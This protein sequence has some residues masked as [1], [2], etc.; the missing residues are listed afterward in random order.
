M[1]SQIASVKFTI[2]DK[3][4]DSDDDNTCTKKR[5]VGEDQD[6]TVF[7]TE[8]SRGYVQSAFRHLHGAHAELL[9]KKTPFYGNDII[10]KFLLK[11]VEFSLH[12]QTSNYKIQLNTCNND[13]Q[14]IHIS[15]TGFHENTHEELI[16]K[17]LPDLAVKRVIEDCFLRGKVNEM[18]QGS[19]R[20]RAVNVGHVYR[21]HPKHEAS[22]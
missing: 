9:A 7:N 8:I 21:I 18:L 6:V 11:F 10:K 22:L 14:D 17:G 5:R 19:S 2:T 3:A 15:V 12:D 13:T 20:R 16:M 1:R 4:S